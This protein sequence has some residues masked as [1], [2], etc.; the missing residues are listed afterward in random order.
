MGQGRRRYAPICELNRSFTF[1]ILSPS[2]STSFFFS[3]A[4]APICFHKP[5]LADVSAPGQDGDPEGDRA[6]KTPDGQPAGDVQDEQPPAAPTPRHDLPLDL[7]SS[8]A[9][10]NDPTA[11]SNVYFPISDLPLSYPSSLDII[12]IRND[13]SFH[14]FI[15]SDF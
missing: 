6:T 8:S 1:P 9:S 11:K 4:T 2:R 10:Q 3:L 14:M 7:S 15:A 5:Q 12:A 13:P